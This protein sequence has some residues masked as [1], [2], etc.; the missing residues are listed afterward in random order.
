[1]AWASILGNDVP[2]IFHSS[3]GASATLAGMV[4]V[5][6]SPWVSSPKPAERLPSVTLPSAI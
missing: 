1:M 2:A 6:F 4:R 5:N 3:A